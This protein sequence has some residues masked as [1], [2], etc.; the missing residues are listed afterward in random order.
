MSEVKLT[1][2]IVPAN[3]GFFVV[4]P[5]KGE[6]TETYIGFDLTPIIAWIIEQDQYGHS[7]SPVLPDAEPMGEMI[8]KYPDGG[9]VLPYDR[10]LDD[11]TAVIEFLNK[12]QQEAK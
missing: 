9:F 12:Q 2:T 4:D 3:P 1:K 8:I 6:E 7:A 11:E 10:R 5:F